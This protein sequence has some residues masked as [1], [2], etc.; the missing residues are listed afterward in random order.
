MNDQ[1]KFM[2]TAADSMQE[3]IWHLARE[4]GCNPE[5]GYQEHYATRLLKGFLEKQGFIV[6][7]PLA[8]M[9]TAFRASFRGRFPGLRIA[10]LA[11][12]DALPDIGH[13]CGHNL[14]GVA[15]VGAAVILSMIRDLPGELVV[16][17][18]PA[19]ETSGAKVALAE[20]GIF[21]DIQAAMMFHPGS[22]NVPEISSLALDAIEVDFYG[23]AAHMAISDHTGINALDALLRFFN[24][25]DKYRR[26]LAKDERIDGII[27]YGGKAPNIVPDKA[28]A[29]FYLRAGKRENLNRIREKFLKYAKKAAEE[30]RAE[31]SWRFYESSYHEMRTNSALAQC[32]R[33]NLFELGVRDIEFPQTMLG[34]VDMG[35]VS[36]VVPAIHPY[37]RLGQGLEIPH[38]L[39]FARAALSKEGEKV[40]GIAVKALSLTGWDVLTDKWL[41]ER[42]IKEFQKR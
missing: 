26:R 40:L 2:I 5:E 9:E 14:I 10:F 41:Q 17:G 16:I 28:S 32:F 31:T 29:R 27:T 25:I 3:P 8:G 38:T 6:E 24:K 34:S 4:I 15:S 30:V 42:I 33:D 11:E 37:L 7:T 13:G 1:K 23:R 18:T 22:S 36:Q 39:E 35:N 12:Y 20:V 19:E 21:H